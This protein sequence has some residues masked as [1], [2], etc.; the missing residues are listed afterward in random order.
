MMLKF[1]FF[2]I[3]FYT[4]E[5]ATAKR[6]LLFHMPFHKVAT[7]PGQVIANSRSLPRTFGCRRK[8]CK[9]CYSK[10]LIPEADDKDCDLQWHFRCIP[11]LTSCSCHCWVHL[12]EEWPKPWQKRSWWGEGR[13]PW[14]RGWAKSRRACGG[15]RRE[16]VQPLSS[17][18]V[19][20]I[21]WIAGVDCLP[22][23]LGLKSLLFLD[24]DICIMNHDLNR[25]LHTFQNMNV[26]LRRTENL[27]EFERNLTENSFP[28]P[29]CEIYSK[30]A[31][32]SSKIGNADELQTKFRYFTNQKSLSIF[33]GLSFLFPLVLFGERSEIHKKFYLYSHSIV[34]VE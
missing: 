19:V 4:N 28:K 7:S 14:C 29:W 13:R 8:Q 17:M 23:K 10:P 21:L 32:N 26:T 9:S 12:R 34:W 16:C 22:L 11:C 24:W 15:R 30:S 20:Q 33:S 3:D 31:G 5:T 2:L 18:N 6:T 1:Y 25:K 27:K